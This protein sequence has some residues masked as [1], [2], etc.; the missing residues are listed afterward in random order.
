MDLL[1]HNE[2]MET[3]QQGKKPFGTS[4]TQYKKDFKNSLYLHNQ[5]TVLLGLNWQILL[6]FKITASNHDEID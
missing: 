5:E 2:K 1:K 6:V 3:Y 4:P